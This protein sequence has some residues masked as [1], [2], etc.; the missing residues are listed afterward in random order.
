MH[1]QQRHANKLDLCVRDIACEQLL[2]QRILTKTRN[3]FLTIT[4]YPAE[5]VILSL[6]FLKII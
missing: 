6:I 3:S 2:F 4:F 5:D 1:S